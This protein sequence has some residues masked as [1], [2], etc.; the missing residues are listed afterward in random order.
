MTQDLKT[1]RDNINGENEEDK[2]DS[3]ILFWFIQIKLNINDF[4]L[5]SSIKS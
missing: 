1:N 3:F 4:I 5:L 2:E